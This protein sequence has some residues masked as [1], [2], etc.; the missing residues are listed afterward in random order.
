LNGDDENQGRGVR[1]PLF[2]RIVARSVASP[3]NVTVAG[4]A[5][6][7]AA[8]LHSW[9]L[10]ALGGAA[11]VALVA[12]DLVSPDFWR[13]ALSSDASSPKGAAKI[14][15]PN[16]IADPGLRQTAAVV[17]GARTKLHALL[18][19][20]TGDVAVQLAG[21]RVAV[22]ELEGRAA[23]LIKNGDQLIR[24]L[25]QSDADG[26]R[27]EIERL[28]G[29]AAQTSDAEARDQYERSV[30][31][32]EE[33]LAAISDIASAV[34]RVYASL[35]RIV[36]TLEG[37]SAKVVRM[38]AMDAQAMD[39]LSGDMNAELERMNREIDTFEQTLRHLVATETA[40]A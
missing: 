3:L 39:N 36:A 20:A 4:A 35:S 40:R 18:D 22:D 16:K 23:G 37:L 19:E 31:T 10:G 38:G 15:S 7:G 13:K 27:R 17:L 8:A 29:R 1:P 28:R 9:P 30:K 6:L 14:P 25:G 2:R 5:A 26:V 33:Q 34:E 21:V 24:Y 32:R 12:W 11:Y